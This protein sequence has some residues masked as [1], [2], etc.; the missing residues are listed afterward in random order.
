MNQTQLISYIA[1]AAPATR[2]PAT[3][4]EAFIRPEIGF[5]PA[6]YRQ[7][8][9]ID[10]GERLH[11]DVPY[12]KQSVLAMRD[13]LRRRFPG[14]AIGGIDREDA[15]LDLLTGLYGGNTVAAILGMPITYY[16]DNW[17]NVQQQHL[18]L[19]MAAK[20]QI[21]DLDSNPFFC[22]LM[23]QVEQIIE[24]EGRCDGFINWQ[25]VINTALRLRGQELLM[26]LVDEPQICQHL[27]DVITTVMIDATRRLRNRQRVS[28][29]DYNFA[30]VSNC[31][32]NMISPELYR[33]FLLPCDCRI[34][35][36]FD[37]IGIHNCAWTADPYLQLYA[38]VPKLGY[39]DMG[40]DSDLVRARQLM[41]QARRALMYTPMDLANKCEA[42]LHADLA[43]IASDYA[44]C[45][46]VV[47]D[48]E[49]GTPDSKVWALIE[50][51]RDLNIPRRGT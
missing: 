28:G 36:A 44:P 15:S 22:Q 43:R 48:I 12:R 13:E 9:D 39:I 32:V 42:E 51:C 8:L 38:I 40:L 19:E 11:T 24:L 26:D 50:I 25:G 23:D 20:L 34:A 21:P 41:P 45:D 3:G 47:A 7:S 16:H 18:T 5:T 33:E 31:S 37:T 4:N 14:T 29:V 46:I 17:P 35:E 10:F 6:W 30:T 2:R 1:P 27:F 49:A